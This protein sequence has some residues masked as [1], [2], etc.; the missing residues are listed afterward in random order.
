MGISRNSTSGCPARKSRSAL[1]TTGNFSATSL[2][3]SRSAPTSPAAVLFYRVFTDPAFVEQARARFKDQLSALLTFYRRTRKKSSHATTLDDAGLLAAT[4]EWNAFRGDARMCADLFAF[5]ESFLR[6]LLRTR[7]RL[8]ESADAHDDHLS[9]SDDH[10]DHGGRDLPDDLAKTNAF[11]HAVE[12]KYP[13]DACIQNIYLSTAATA[14]VDATAEKAATD[15]E[16]KEDQA[17]RADKRLGA[18]VFLLNSVLGELVFAPEDPMEPFMNP[19]LREGK[20]QLAQMHFRRRLMRNVLCPAFERFHAG[21]ARMLRLNACVARARERERE[22]LRA[23][24]KDDEKRTR[25]L[26]S[27]P[28]CCSCSSSSS[29]ADGGGDDEE[30][31]WRTQLQEVQH[32]STF[33]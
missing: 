28:P 26:L 31:Y 32:N 33:F 7:V 10:H 11:L 20:D 30:T 15:E 25:L 12:Q 16:E 27:A 9:D 4:M 23:A 13:L 8:R 24:R 2:K 6:Q 1:A 21:K 5:I 29:A 14:S 22:L 17:F 18:F 3:P 19:S